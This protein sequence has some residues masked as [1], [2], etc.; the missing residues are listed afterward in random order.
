MAARLLSLILPQNAN[1][2][3]LRGGRKGLG[4]EGGVLATRVTG[5]TASVGVNAPISTDVTT[6]ATNT[7]AIT[8]RVNYLT[9]AAGAVT[10]TLPLVSGDVREVI[11][12]KNGAN[13]V[14]VNINGADSGNII[15]SAG[16]AAGN[17]DTVSTATT[18]R[19]LSDGTSWYRVL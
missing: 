11:I 14:T 9:H 10:A 18:A 3:Y 1:W 7:V 6:D 8:T 12:I 13:D 4:F 15:L 19:Y 17:S 2:R 16:A 5:S